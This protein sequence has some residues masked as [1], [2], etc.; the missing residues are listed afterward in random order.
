MTA[1]DDFVC[2]C[3]VIVKDEGEK[4]PHC[5]AVEFEIRLAEI[6]EGDL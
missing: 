1:N 6:K 3:G 4:C 5:Q 2:E